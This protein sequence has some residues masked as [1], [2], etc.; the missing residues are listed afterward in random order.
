MTDLEIAQ[1]NERL[2]TAYWEWKKGLKS[3][4]EVLRIYEEEG[5]FKIVRFVIAISGL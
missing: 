2:Y 4:E 5:Q 1:R 3:A